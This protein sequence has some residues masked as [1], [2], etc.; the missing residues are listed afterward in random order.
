MDTRALGIVEVRE[1]P[2]SLDLSPEE[3]AA[4]ADEL[5]EYH[6]QFSEVYSRVEQ[7]PWG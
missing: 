3:I 7:A 1:I 2:P 6:G 4:L 5:L